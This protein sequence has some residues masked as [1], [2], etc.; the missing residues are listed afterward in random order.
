VDNEQQ[1][2]RAQVPVDEEAETEN[3]PTPEPEF[4]VTV[5]KLVVPARPR[6]VLAE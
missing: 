5:R 6:G 1:T 4:K 2:E 3:Q